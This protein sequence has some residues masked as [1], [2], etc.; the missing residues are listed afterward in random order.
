MQKPSHY[1]SVFTSGSIRVEMTKFITHNNVAV[2]NLAVVNTG[3]SSATLQL[4]ATSPYATTVSGN[5]LTGR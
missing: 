3:G 5:E 1:K 2:T 4:R